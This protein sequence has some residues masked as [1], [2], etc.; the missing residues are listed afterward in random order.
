MWGQR[1]KRELLTPRPLRTER[2]KSANV[3]MC[4]GG[5]RADGPH[6]PIEWF[7][8]GVLNDQSYPTRGGNLVLSGG[9]DQ[10]LGMDEGFG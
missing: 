9:E 5:G 10:G 3:R 6:R 7:V 2:G 4:E 1:Q 8:L